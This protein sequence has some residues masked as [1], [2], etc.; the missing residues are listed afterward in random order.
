MMVGVKMGILHARKTKA[1]L[2]LMASRVVSGKQ[3]TTI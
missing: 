2:V 3:M 1:A